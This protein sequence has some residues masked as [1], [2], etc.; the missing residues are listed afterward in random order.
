MSLHFGKCRIGSG[1]GSR[2]SQIFSLSLEN[3][4]GLSNTG[5]RLALAEKK[6]LHFIGYVLSIHTVCCFESAP[7]SQ[8]S[9]LRFS[10]AVEVQSLPCT[11]TGSCSRSWEMSV[12]SYWEAGLVLVHKNI[13]FCDSV[14]ILSNFSLH[15]KKIK[16]KNK[17]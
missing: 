5:D 11:H 2:L 14:I 10:T 13:K 17:K 16:I 9:K 7:V 1:V 15:G 3:S 8:S 6:L 4:L 12:R